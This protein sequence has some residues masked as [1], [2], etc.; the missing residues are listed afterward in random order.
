MTSPASLDILRHQ[1][2]EDLARDSSREVVVAFLD[3]LL[4]DSHT[5]LGRLTE[6]AKLGDLATCE[7]LAHRCKS[8]FGSAGADGLF[9]AFEALEQDIQSGTLL[10]S[11]LPSRVAPLTAAFATVEA[12]LLEWQKRNA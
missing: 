2:L 4:T 6:A 11:Q 12:H 10:G 8:S 5:S 9:L 1:A 3:V 7:R